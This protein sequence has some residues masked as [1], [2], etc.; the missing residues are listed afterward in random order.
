M[1]DVVVQ[2]VGV[3]KTYHQESVPIHALKEVDFEVRAGEFVSL[4][5][6]RVRVNRPCLTSL[7]A[8]TGR[9]RVRS[10]WMAWI[11]VRCP[12]RHWPACAC[13]SWVSCFQ[14]YNL[15]PVL[16]AAENVEFIMQLQGVGAVER[17]RRAHEILSVLGL[18][19]MIDRRPGEM[20]GGQQQRVL[21]WRGR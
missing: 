10:W 6:R 3:G 1:N 14:A 7:A 9:T 16:T 13:I 2:C 4:S 19:D 18:G 5:G 17:R 15:I 20:S 8:W 11:W 21:R 12:N